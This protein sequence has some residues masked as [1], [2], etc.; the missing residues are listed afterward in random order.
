MTGT[1]ADVRPA[2][3]PRRR[4][5]GSPGPNR[6]RSFVL[7]LIGII[8]LAGLIEYISRAGIIDP[9]FLPSFSSTVLRAGSLIVDPEFLVDFATTVATFVLGLT[10]A[11]V[12]GVAA[13]VLVGLSDTVYRATRTVVEL[14]RP[15]PPVAL[16]PLAILVLGTNLEMKLGIALFAAI[17]PILF[18]TM[19]GVHNVDPAARDMGRVFGRSRSDIIRTIVIPSAG[20][21]IWT[22]VRMSTTISMVVIITVELIAGSNAGIGAFIANARNA[23]DPQ[24]VYAAIILA[25]LLGL[26]INQL[27]AFLERR[28]FR[29]AMGQERA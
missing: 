7:P 28:L 15:L 6:V 23:G 25:G 29:W 8:A 27:M 18:N 17:W 19:Y 3:S 4:R 20:P 26:L 13:G 5:S 9:L 2:T 11:T 16:I 12:V 1:I 10:L 21:Q 24:A 22:G 14:I